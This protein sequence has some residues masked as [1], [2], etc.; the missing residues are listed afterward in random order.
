MIKPNG[1]MQ[2]NLKDRHIKRSITFYV[3]GGVGYEIDVDGQKTCHF[4]LEGLSEK[5]ISLLEL[6]RKNFLPEEKIRFQGREYKNTLLLQNAEMH[7][8]GAKIKKKKNS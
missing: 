7:R 2:P 3:R 8:I 1:S 6:H 4:A 5:R